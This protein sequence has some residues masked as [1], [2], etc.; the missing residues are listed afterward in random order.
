M[1]SCWCDGVRM[2][3]VGYLTR[4]VP[5][6]LIKTPQTQG[7][8]KRPNRFP[9]SRKVRPS[10]MAGSQRRVTHRYTFLRLWFRSEVRLHLR[11]V[12]FT[13]P[14]S[15]DPRAW[16]L[17]ELNRVCPGLHVA[18]RS[19]YINLA[20]LMWSFRILERPDAPIDVNG[21]TAAVVSRAPPFEADFVP[22]M[23]EKK[24]REIMEN[25]HYIG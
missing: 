24:L 23:E 10:A 15:Q 3:L 5:L 1:Y 19:L 12:R 20:L 25:T 18:N 11:V 9:R 17:F 22:R 6:T 8:L 21:F 16:A 2:S 14:L 7:D 13:R 4:Y